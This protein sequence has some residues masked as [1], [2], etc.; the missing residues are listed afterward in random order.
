MNYQLTVTGDGVRVHTWSIP[1]DT[2]AGVSTG[3]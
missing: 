3:R 2:R 1:T